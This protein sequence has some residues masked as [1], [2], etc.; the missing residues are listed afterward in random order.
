MIK[1]FL[2]I[3]KYY[4]FSVQCSDFNGQLFKIKFSKERDIKLCCRAS[5][6]CSVGH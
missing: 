6:H 1:I 2:S 4:T 5:I 3:T